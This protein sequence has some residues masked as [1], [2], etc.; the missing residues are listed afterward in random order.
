MNGKIDPVARGEREN[1]DGKLKHRSNVGYIKGRIKFQEQYRSKG[2]NVE[3]GK[4][5]YKSRCQMQN[6]ERKRHWEQWEKG[7]AKR[8]VE[9]NKTRR[10]EDRKIRRSNDEKMRRFKDSKRSQKVPKTRPRSR[11]QGFFFRV[12]TR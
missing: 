1:Q 12:K 3:K 6:A 8:E 4:K 5:K 11:G 7:L 9:E 2:E 10:S